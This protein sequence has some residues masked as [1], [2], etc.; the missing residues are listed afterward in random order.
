[1][2][3]GR[4]Q[5]PKKHQT[6]RGRICLPTNVSSLVS[7]L[8][9]LTCR[10]PTDCPRWSS[11]SLEWD[12]SLQTCGLAACLY[13]TKKPFPQDRANYTAATGISCKALAGHPGKPNGTSHWVSR[14]GGR[15]NFANNARCGCI[16]CKVLGGR[17][18]GGRE[19][20]LQGYKII[21]VRVCDIVIT[22]TTAAQ[23]N[24]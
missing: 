1:M 4:G 24:S 15:E 22:P 20:C 13:S 23:P 16:I 21:C 10:P 7:C 5:T 3:M 19:R 11:T 17:P 8:S 14:G 2:R 9:C 12:P 6:D 18:R